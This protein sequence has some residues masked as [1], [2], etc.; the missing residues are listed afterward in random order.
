MAKQEA[1]RAYDKALGL[2]NITKGNSDMFSDLLRRMEDF[3]NQR[4]ARPAEIRAVGLSCPL[5]ETIGTTQGKHK[6]K[7]HFRPLH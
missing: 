4:G 7:Y 5:F 3:Q 1:Q 2:L 6:L